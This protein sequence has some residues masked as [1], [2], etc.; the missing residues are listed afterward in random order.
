MKFSKIFYS[1]V[2]RIVNVVT[3]MVIHH[4]QSNKRGTKINIVVVENLLFVNGFLH[5]L[6]RQKQERVIC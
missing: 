6:K 4:V 5:D 3:L 2:R 1:F